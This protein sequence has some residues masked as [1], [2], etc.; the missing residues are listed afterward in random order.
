MEKRPFSEFGLSS[1]LTQAID[2]LGFE[3]ASPIQ[4]ASIPLLLEGGDIVGHSP[5]GSG[6][7]AAFGIPIIEKTDP[8]IRRPQAI[9]LCPTRELAIQVSQEIHK[10]CAFKK[11]VSVVP[12]YGGAPFDRQAQSLRKGAQ[13]VIGTPGRVLDHI[14][15]KTLDLEGIRTAV[16][17]EADEMLD[18]GFLEDITTILESAPRERQTVFFSATMPQA[19]KKLISR[20]ANKP[21]MVAFEGEKLSTPSIEQVYYETRYRSKPEILSRLLDTLDARLSIVFCNTK[22]AVDELVDNLVARGYSADRLHGDM[23]Q[24]MRTRVMNSFRSGTVEVLVATDVAARGIDVDAV[25][26]VFNYDLPFDA[27]D[28][29][30][31]IGRT[32]R[33]G[34]EGKA[35]TFVAGRDV[36]KLQNIQRH[37]KQPIARSRVPT[38]DELEERRADRFYDRLHGLLEGGDF[39]K[40][41][42][43]IDRL[44][45]QGFSP[46]EI[47]AAALHLLLESSNRDAEPIPEDR[48]QKG[49]PRKRSDKHERNAPRERSNTH[50]RGNPERPD[51]APQQRPVPAASGGGGGTATLFANIGKIMDVSPG[52]I[53]GALYNTVHLPQGSIGKITLFP[54]HALI[55]VPE[56]HVDEILQRAGSMK[57]RGKDVRFTRDRYNGEHPREHAGGFQGER[58]HKGRGGFKKNWGQHESSRDDSREGDRGGYKKSYSKGGFASGKFRGPSKQWKKGSKPGK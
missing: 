23:P 47:T 52:D 14:R 30:H 40:E 18:M 55:Q 12:V 3:L 21:E 27:E 41:A 11:G 16:L 20:F 39:P 22:R 58:P 48:P 28:Y 31:R 35:I 32:G 34:R 50:E 45:S 24:G 36:Y 43:I 49:A 56:N 46:T 13:V 9:V 42:R 37:T 26:L 15:R 54:K 8:S 51:H 57:I 4:S 38:L 1:E 5:T 44:F 17:D 25:D 29:V 53:A 10:L 2:Q 33:A 6:K 19:I 7:T